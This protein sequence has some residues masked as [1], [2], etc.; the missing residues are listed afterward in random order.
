[1]AHETDGVTD[2]VDGFGALEGI[3]ELGQ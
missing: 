2:K 3:G 1:L